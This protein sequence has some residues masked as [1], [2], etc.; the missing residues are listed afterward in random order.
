M[1]RDKALGLSVLTFF[2]FSQEDS[3][4]PAAV[5]GIHW[6]RESYS[7]QSTE[8]AAIGRVSPPSVF[9]KQ[10]CM[11]MY[12]NG[13]AEYQ[14]ETIGLFT[15]KPP[16]LFHTNKRGKPTNTSGADTT[17]T[18][19]TGH[20]GGPRPSSASPQP[21]HSF[22]KTCLKTPDLRLSSNTVIFLDLCFLTSDF[23][24]SNFQKVPIY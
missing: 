5:S 17:G 18:T 10:S 14:Q 8:E 23:Y 2:P 19:H 15:R 11:G 24:S 21:Q 7:K 22:F 12:Y 4:L 6:W 20:H 9:I 3:C 16:P 1:V 13:R